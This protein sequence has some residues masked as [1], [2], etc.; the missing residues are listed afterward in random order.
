MPMPLPMARDFFFRPS[1][2]WYGTVIDFQSIPAK[3]SGWASRLR[4]TLYKDK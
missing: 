3:A 4:M 2:G 1:A